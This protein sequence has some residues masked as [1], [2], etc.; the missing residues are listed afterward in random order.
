MLSS[1]TLAS[2]NYFVERRNIL[3]S[4]HDCY[5]PKRLANLY[6]YLHMADR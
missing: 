1:G 2:L 5:A 6:H 3:L 4:C